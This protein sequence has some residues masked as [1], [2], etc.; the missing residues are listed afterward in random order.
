MTSSRLFSEIRF[1]PKIVGPLVSLGL[2]FSDSRLAARTSGGKCAEL[3]AETGDLCCFWGFSLPLACMATLGFGDLFGGT[4]SG[5]SFG[6]KIFGEVFGLEKPP[7]EPVV[8]MDDFGLESVA[9]GACL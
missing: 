5:S 8:L 4:F 9:V 1:S 2:G 3:F 6:T 7:A